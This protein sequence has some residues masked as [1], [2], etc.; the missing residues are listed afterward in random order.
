[1][2]KLLKEANRIIQLWRAYGPKRSSI[3]LEQVFYEVV[4]PTSGGDNCQIV[5]DS[6]E[7]FEGLMAR[8]DASSEWRIGINLN[9][10]YA[11]RRNFTLA[12][13]IG[14]FIGHRILQDAF[15]CT[16]DNLNDFQNSGLELEANEFASH[17]LMP[18]DILRTFDKEQCF[19]HQT[20]SELSTMLNVSRAAA[21]YRWIRLSDRR[22]GFA[23][24]RDGFISQGRASDRL[25]AQGTFFKQGCE[26]PDKSLATQLSAAGQELVG[27]ASDPMWNDAFPCKE[28]SFATIQG[29][30]VYTYLDF[31][32]I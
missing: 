31:D 16:F 10:S 8:A 12:H 19:C 2:A 20:V 17:L 27:I 30:Y 9:I 32:R 24:S 15:Y 11:P 3:D 5:Y 1:M 25:Y 21:A 28:S 29:G 13:E 6:F 22:I 23:I 7:S 4:L 26:V 18:P 14:H